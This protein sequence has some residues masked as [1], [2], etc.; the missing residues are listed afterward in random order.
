MINRQIFFDAVRKAPFSGT[1]SAGQLEGLQAILDEWERRGLTDRRWL[2]YM[3]ATAFHETGATMQPI[4]EKGGDAY[5]KRM[6]DPHGA[7]PA[8]AKKNGNV[9]PGDG[10]RY[11]GRGLPQLTWR[12]NYRRMGRLL[13]LPLEENPDLALRMDVAVQI[14]FEGMLGGVY[15]GKRLAQY[16]NA[17][18]D[19]PKGARKIVNGTDKAAKIAGYHKAF[20]AALEAASEAG[21]VPEAAVPLPRARPPRPRHG[22]AITDEAIIKRAQIQLRELGYSEI[23]EPDGSIET[24]A[25]GAI[26]AFRNDNGLPLKPI[27]DDEFMLA[28]ATARPRPISPARENATAEDIQESVP[29]VK[30]TWWSRLWAK[31]TAGIAGLGLSGGALSDWSDTAREWISPIRQ[32]LGA[33]PW[34]GWLTLVLIGAAVWWRSQRRVESKIV[35]LHQ[36][37]R[38][39]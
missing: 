26:L 15:T 29:V 10:V 24:F 21:E 34:Y 6:Y 11:A 23:G 35:E 3:L 32:L 27:I 9:Y 8:L 31:I 13:G 1:I 37:A 18:T 33:V 20:L 2:A 28:L 25:E 16:F 4:K 5:L 7:R 38:L 39:R 36:E 22:E 30:D 12:N 19:D 17:S 14:M